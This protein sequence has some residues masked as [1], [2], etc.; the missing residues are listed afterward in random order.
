M[1]ARGLE[2]SSEH[3]LFIHRDWQS[4]EKSWIDLRPRGTDMKGMMRCG[5]VNGDVWGGGGALKSKWKR[6]SNWKQSKQAENLTSVCF[7]DQ[8]TTQ[9]CQSERCFSGR[10]N[11]LRGDEWVKLTGPGHRKK[12]SVLCWPK[13]SSVAG[14]E[15]HVYSFCGWSASSSCRGSGDQWGRGQRLGNPRVL[16]QGRICRAWAKCCCCVTAPS[17]KGRGWGGEEGCTGLHLQPSRGPAA[18]HSLGRH[19]SNHLGGNTASWWGHSN[20]SCSEGSG[21]DPQMRKLFLGC[22]VGRYCSSPFILRIRRG[23]GSWGVVFSPTGRDGRSLCVPSAVEDDGEL[24]DLAHWQSCSGAVSW[25]SIGRA[26][27]KA[28]H[29]SWG[30]SSQREQG[31]VKSKSELEKANGIVNSIKTKQNQQTYPILNCLLGNFVWE[32]KMKSHLERSLL[33]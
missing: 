9:R 16:G 2:T 11:E 26:W 33:C 4:P 15:E 28:A 22:E 23:K 1:M 25:C 17:D 5:I 6:E 29:S 12:W 3:Q 19:E 13:P 24:A 10:I 18:F 30:T 31:L 27:A 14:H 32:W 20:N 21:Y 7:W 8:H